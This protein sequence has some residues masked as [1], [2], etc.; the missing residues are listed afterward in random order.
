MVKF[1]H[2]L[3]AALGVRTKGYGGLWNRWYIY[4]QL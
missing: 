4:G 2:A 1:A 3:K